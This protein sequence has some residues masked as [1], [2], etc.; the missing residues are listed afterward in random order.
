IA[1][2]LLR[3]LANRLTTLTP[4]ENVGLACSCCALCCCAPSRRRAGRRPRAENRVRREMDS[5]NAIGEMRDARNGGG[6][7]YRLLA[8]AAGDRRTQRVPRPVLL[9]T[10]GFDE[11]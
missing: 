7:T 11:S 5:S 3:T 1:P 2:V 8:R 6:V 9:V 10:E 4:V